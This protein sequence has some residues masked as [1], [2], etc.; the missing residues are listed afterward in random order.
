MAAFRKLPIMMGVP[1]TFS[2]TELKSGLP[3]MAAINWVRT[4]LTSDVTMELKAAPKITATARSTTFPRKTKSR[5]P[6]SISLSCRWGA[7][8]PRCV[9][10]A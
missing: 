5:N 7:Q 1:F 8:L 6:L 10:R 2:I 4:S 3:T 9:N